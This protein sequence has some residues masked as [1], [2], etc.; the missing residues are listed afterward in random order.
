MLSYQKQ[1]AKRRTNHWISKFLILN[2]SNY[3][4]FF[5]QLRILEGCSFFLG[6]VFDPDC[7][8][9]GTIVRTKILQRIKR[10][11][12]VA[13]MPNSYETWSPRANVGVRTHSVLNQPKTEF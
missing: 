4:M 8:S 6:I 13:K 3:Q 2:V 7:Q 5:C 12:E 10:K 9:G 11:F 1:T